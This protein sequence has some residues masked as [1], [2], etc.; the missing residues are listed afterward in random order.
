[1]ISL[2]ARVHSE[3]VRILGTTEHTVK[4]SVRTFR[5]LGM[6]KLGIAVES[7]SGRYRVSSKT[8]RDAKLAVGWS[9]SYFGVIGDVLFECSTRRPCEIRSRKLSER[10]TSIRTRSSAGSHEPRSTR[11][12]ISSDSVESG[13]VRFQGIVLARKNADG[14]EGT[15]RGSAT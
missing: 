2:L 6:R 11:D 10:Q 4:Y 3:S 8:P 7:S 12:S 5:G 14:S 13:T 15:S 9:R 1:M